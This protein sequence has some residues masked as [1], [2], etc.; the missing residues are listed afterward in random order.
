M[1]SLPMNP[2]DLTPDDRKQLEFHKRR[3]ADEYLFRTSPADRPTVQ[4]IVSALYRKINFEPPRHFLWYDSPL[5]GVWAAGLLA[6]PHD[7]LLESVLKNM[8]QTRAGVSKIEEIR[9]Q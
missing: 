6:E 2:A 1:D 7:W 5:G 9:G 8:Q 3:W 4:D